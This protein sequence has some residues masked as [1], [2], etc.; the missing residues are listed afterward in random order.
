MK[1]SK[2]I[3][4]LQKKRQGSLDHTEKAELDIWEK[5]TQ[6]SFAVDDLEKIWSWSGKYK[7]SYEPD[8]EAGLARFKSRIASETA[9]EKQ[10]RPRASKTGWWR[11]AAAIAFLLACTWA[12]NR[13]ANAPT[14]EL[15]VV[16]K[17]GEQKNVRLPDGSVV[18]LNQ[19]SILSYPKSFK[20]S[21]HRNVRLEGEAFFDIASNPEQPFRIYTAESEVQ[22]LGTSF[23]VRAYP[24]EAFTEVDVLTGKVAFESR[25]HTQKVQLEPEETAIFR[26]D[27]KLV[28]EQDRSLAN[29]HSWRTG[30][31]KFRG[32][33]LYEVLQALE[34]HYSVQIDGNFSKAL[35]CAV[36]TNFE[37]VELQTVIET[38]ELQ[39]NLKMKQM[40]KASFRI[41][42]GT[43]N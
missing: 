26:H 37:E 9:I 3:L 43:C 22:V 40:D 13:Y 39:Y 33:A 1:L 16:A 12:I 24:E 14:V 17:A 5:A 8:V 6:D 41:E 11:V 18:V 35:S 38:L 15:Q 7:E 25:D 32:T 23:N 30:Q 21:D 34:R 31:L 19:N 4:L 42:G 36:T 27:D 20:S 28:K 2:Y 10:M 29:A